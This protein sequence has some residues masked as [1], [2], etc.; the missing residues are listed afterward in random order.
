MLVNGKMTFSM[1][2]AK[3]TGL[4]EAGTM[5]VIA[6]VKS[7]AKVFTSGLMAQFTTVIG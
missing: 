4:M 6:L 3:K 5:V 7:M 2:K 1:V